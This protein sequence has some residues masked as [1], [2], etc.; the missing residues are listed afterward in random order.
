MLIEMVEGEPPLFNE[1]PLQAMRRIRDFPPPNL[2][3]PY[4]A[5]TELQSFL[6]RTLVRDISLRASASELL[7]HSF[8][9]R[10]QQASIICPLLRDCSNFRQ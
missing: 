9:K 6:S 7:C 1:Q 8:L 10:A 2:N 3:R 5:S 4:E